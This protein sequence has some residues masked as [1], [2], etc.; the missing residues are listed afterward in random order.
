[1]IK[2][3]LKT[4]PE[5]VKMMRECTYH[6]GD[7]LLNYHHLE[8]DIW[9]HTV[10][11]YNNGINNN[12]SEEVLWALLL[13]DIGRVHTKKIDTVKNRVHFGDFEGVSCFVAL[14]I[15]EKA[16]VS[17]NNII[18]ILKII[19]FQYTIIDYIKYDTPS[20]NEL[21]SMFKYEEECLKDLSEYVKCDLF[22]RIIDE[23]KRKYYNINKVNEFILYSDTIINTEKTQSTKN[24]TVYI[25][26]GPPCSRKS[27]WVESML[28]EHIVVN[29]DACVEKI[30]KKY[31]KKGYDDSYDLMKKNKD[32]K[33]EVDNLD[34]SIENCAKNSVNKDI[35]IDNPNLKIKNRKEWIDAFCRTHTI[36]V[37]LFLTPFNDLLICSKKRSVSSGKTIS[38]QNTINKLMTLAFPLLSE[39][40]DSIEYV[41][42][43]ED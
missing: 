18:R 35:I 15:L 24:N 2:W 28:D 12:V 8:G 5:Y 39:G 22:G 43:L 6:N 42:N 7:N 3:F 41:F 17:K 29:R 37:V 14:E 16:K 27:T 1:M 34:E 31:G 26:V 25:L 36:K 11:S 20:K 33:K 30:G 23:S 9:S 10:M 4:Y 38:K 19:S 32:V 13:H 40:I 21:L